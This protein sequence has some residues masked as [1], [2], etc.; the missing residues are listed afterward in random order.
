MYHERTHSEV[1]ARRL[2]GVVV[3]LVVLVI[4]AAIVVGVL[5][6]Q[7]TAREQG[8]T[9][10]RESILATAMQCYAIEGSYPASLAHLED[11]YGLTVNHDDYV[12]NYE[13]FADNVPPSVAVSVR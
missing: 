11:V 7:K 5:A 4:M 10:I 9:S 6:F 1:R 12:I 8:A 13:W 3:T 2:R